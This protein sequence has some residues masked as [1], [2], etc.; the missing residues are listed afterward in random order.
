MTLT[1]ESTTAATADRSVPPWQGTNH[2]ALITADMDATVRFYA[3]VLGM[4][5]VAAVMAGPARH[6]FFEMGESNTVAFFEWAGHEITPKAAGA[7]P[8]PQLQLDHISF[9][10]PDR[11][12]LE[13]LRARLESFD[14]EVTPIVDH[15]IVHSI[16]FTD[17]NGIALEASYWSRDV[18]G[19]SANRDNFLNDPDPVP[20]LTEIR[21][22]GRVLSTPT[23]RLV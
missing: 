19:P 17:N 8:Q 14:V 22:H 7:R 12:S 4:E 3:G 18:T 6:Y 15:T 11:G 10:V 13:A 23:T 9:G 20:A 21:E 1:N 2:L 5:L 16:Y